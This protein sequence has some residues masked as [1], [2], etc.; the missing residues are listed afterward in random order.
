MRYEHELMNRRKVGCITALS[1]KFD[2]ATL[3]IA[4]CDEGATYQEKQMQL[5]LLTI[6]AEVRGATRFVVGRVYSESG[7]VKAYHVFFDIDLET[8]KEI[9][10]RW[11]L[12]PYEVRAVDMRRP[13]T[14]QTELFVNNPVPRYMP[15]YTS[16][17]T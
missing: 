14:F 15:M 3:V 5:R 10:K 13:E 16:S 7:S 2:T 9:C 8:G 4:R 17:W 12:G 11:K 1:E 6:R